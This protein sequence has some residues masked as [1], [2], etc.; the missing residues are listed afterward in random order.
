MFHKKQKVDKNSRFTAEALR[1]RR[2][3]REKR[4]RGKEEKRRSVEEE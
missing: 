3:P 4:S 1:T 2:K